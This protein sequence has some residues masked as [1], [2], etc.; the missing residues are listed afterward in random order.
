MLLTSTKEEDIPWSVTYE[1]A[2]GRCLNMDS[3]DWNPNRTYDCIVCDQQ[4]RSWTF[5]G[6]THTYSELDSQMASLCMQM[7]TGQN[8][9]VY[10]TEY[11]PVSGDDKGRILYLQNQS[12]AALP[13]GLADSS[14]LQVNLAGNAFTHIPHPS[15][16]CVPWKP[17]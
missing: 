15:F 17:W 5:T 12:L 9:S 3:L 8:T 2:D 11:S 14:F 10:H 6:S 4:V 16:E 7:A 13:E 1:A